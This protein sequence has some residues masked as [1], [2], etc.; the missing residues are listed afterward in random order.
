M[1]ITNAGVRGYNPT[2]VVIHNED[3]TNGAHAGFY[4]NCYLIITL[5]MALL[6]FIM[7]MTED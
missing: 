1:N 6:M 4:N 7:E 2:G 5:K 3:G